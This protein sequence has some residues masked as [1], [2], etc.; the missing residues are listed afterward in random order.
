MQ[1]NKKQHRKKPVPQDTASRYQSPPDLTAKDMQQPII[2]I[3][4]APAAPDPTGIGAMSGLLA[5]QNLFK[6][7][8]GLEGTQ[9]I[10][11]ERET[12]ASNT[13]V[14][15]IQGNKNLSDD[16]KQ[17]AI[18]KQTDRPKNRRHQP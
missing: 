3:Q 1:K 6:D 4:N 7:L 15:A 16:Q 18:A 9:K 8:T 11:L 5:T 2:N 14:A 10:A 12:D 13:K 17:A